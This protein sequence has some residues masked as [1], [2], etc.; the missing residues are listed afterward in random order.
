ME[1]V[2]TNGTIDINV[3]GNVFVASCFLFGMGIGEVPKEKLDYMDPQY[4]VI[5]S[6]KTIK[7]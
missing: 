2:F 6:V 1:E 5:I 4:Q 7:I 3:Y